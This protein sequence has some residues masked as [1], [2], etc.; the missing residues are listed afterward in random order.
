MGGVALAKYDT[1][2]KNQLSDDVRILVQAKLNNTNKN[3]SPVPDRA[4]T[5]QGRHH[6][7]HDEFRVGFRLREDFR[8]GA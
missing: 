2:S 8:E 1:T 4:R 5:F 7:R 6:V 3:P